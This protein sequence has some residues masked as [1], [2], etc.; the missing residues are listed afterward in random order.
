MKRKNDFGINFSVYIMFLSVLIIAMA[1][2]QV[3]QAEVTNYVINSVTLIAK[4]QLRVEV[5]AKYCE[6]CNPN[7]VG[8]PGCP[9]PFEHNPPPYGQKICL[10][11]AP[12]NSP[13]GTYAAVRVKDTSD[14]V[15]G[16]QK[17]VLQA[18]VN[19]TLNTVCTWNI[20]LSASGVSGGQKVIVE[21]DLFCSWCSHWYPEPVEM[22]VK[23]ELPAEAV[24][25]DQTV[26]QAS[27][28]GTVVTLDGS[29]STGAGP[30]T[31]T[32]KEGATTLG[33]GVTLNHEFQ[34]GVHNITLTVS[35]G[36]SSDSDNAVITVVDTTPPSLVVPDDIVAEQTD[37]DGTPVD[38]NV[39]ATDICDADVDI[40]DDS[41]AVYPLGETI[42]TYI[43]TD[44]SGN[45]SEDSI[46][47]TIVDTTP[48][49]LVVPDYIERE[50]ET[51]EGTVVVID[52]TA[53][54]I[55]DADV[56]IYADGE[57]DIYP[58]GSTIVTYTAVDDSGNE[59]MDSV[60]VT[61]VDTTPPEISD[62]D[63]GIIELLWPP[64][65]FYHQ[66]SIVDLLDAQGVTITDICDVDV[67]IYDVMIV[68]VSSDEPENETGDGDG[69]TDDDIV[70]INDQTV[71]L[72]SERQGVGNGR[73]YT[74][75]YAVEDF[76]GNVAYGSCQVG[77]PHDQA[78]KSPV[79][80]GPGSGYT[81]YP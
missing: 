48:P 56:D 72:R 52:V 11:G 65:H 59:S 70:I 55:C 74:I 68:S 24:V 7:P 27:S 46:S 33:T 20:V 14:S 17:I 50:Q 35:N 71:D 47:I 53:T 40:V 36:S 73:V 29:G 8:S 49:D 80:D 57:L 38:I 42:V 41:L 78:H 12:P 51:A 2:A 63:P 81:V 79:D 69:N 62:P 3:A 19:L 22:Q 21:A 67:S 13:D 16:M 76:T 61:I 44:D 34:L 31:Y 32:W 43:A 10:H 60:T 4:D 39:T 28:T 15:L 77:V 25:P 18:G 45:V 54:D 66:I 26:E 75:N 23:S 1:W 5:Q 37:M 6:L 58:L 30:L 9:D 64:N